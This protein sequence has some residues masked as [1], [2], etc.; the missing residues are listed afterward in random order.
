MESLPIIAINWHL[1]FLLLLLLLLP[2][3]AHVA[4]WDENAIFQTFL[5]LTHSLTRSLHSNLD[6]SISLFT[7]LSLSLSSPITAPRE[8]VFESWQM[9]KVNKMKRMKVINSMWIIAWIISFA[10]KCDTLNFNL[11]CFK[12]KWKCV[13]VREK[14][15]EIEVVEVFFWVLFMRIVYE[16]RSLTLPWYLTQ[17]SLKGLSYGNYLE[18]SLE[19]KLNRKKWKQIISVYIVINFTFIPPNGFKRKTLLGNS[20]IYSI[21]VI[22]V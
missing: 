3:H 11:N 5:S 15:S 1:F 16:K 17:N 8:S 10:W 4:N 22:I 6:S 12:G 9:G 19:R 2:W 7:F 21:R 18:N 13:T 20:S 14:E